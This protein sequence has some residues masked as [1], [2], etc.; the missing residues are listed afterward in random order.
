MSE[1]SIFYAILGR[2]RKRQTR[3]IARF[4]ER[5]GSITLFHRVIPV[6]NSF[7]WRKRQKE[8]KPKKYIP[9]NLVYWTLC[10]TLLVNINAPKRSRH[11]I[12]SDQD[13]IAQCG[14]LVSTSLSCGRPFFSL[15]LW[16]QCPACR[17]ELLSSL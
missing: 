5:G 1:I 3:K 8:T 4:R 2:K 15:C 16:L 17:E 14:R 12:K 11:L 9:A 10:C 13:E 6:T 7:F